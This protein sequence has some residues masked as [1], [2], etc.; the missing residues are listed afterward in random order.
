MKLTLGILVMVLVV[1]IAVCTAVSIILN[2]QN[3]EIS[4]D[5][6][7]KSLNIVRDDLILRKEKLMSDTHQLSR[8]NSMGSRVKYLNEF[9]DNKD[10][11]MLKDTYYEIISDMLQIGINSNLWKIAVYDSDGD[12]RT[13][14]ANNGQGKL[15][16]GYTYFAPKFTVY[17][18]TLEP[19][20]Q[21]TTDACQKTGALPQVGIPLK[22]GRAI[23]G[24]E[25]F[26]F[27]QLQNTLSLTA[28]APATATAF[29]KKTKRPEEIQTGLIVCMDKLGNAFV[30]R[31]SRLTG[32]RINVFGRKGLSVGDLKAYKTLKMA[33][34]GDRSGA[35]MLKDQK[36]LLNDV[37]VDDTAYYQGV[38][39]L[40]N[41]EGRV[42]A[43]AALQSKGV[44]Y[45]RTIQMIELLGLV[46]LA[47]I[48]LIIPFA[49]W[50]SNSLTKPVHRAAS[51]LSEMIEE[52][53]TASTQVSSSTHV[54][55]EGTSEQAA[56]LEE[57]ASS[58]EEMSSM[59]GRSA[60]NASEA[61][62]LMRETN[63]I[64][65]KA[66]ESMD[67]LSGSMGE[68]SK[69]SEE[70]SRI[71]K[72]I[73]E[74]AFQTNL[75]ALNAAVE[76]ARAGE[77]GAGFAVV[78][79]EVRNL[80]MRAAEAAKDTAQL[81]EGTVK[82][83][84]GGTE[85]VTETGTAFA[86]VNTNTTKAGE[87]IN[88]ISLA[89]NEQAQG[90]EQVNKAVSEMDRVVQQNAASSEESAAAAQELDRQAVR[91]KGIIEDLNAITGALAKDMAHKD[92]HRPIESNARVNRLP[93]GKIDTES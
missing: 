68:I 8:V 19:G 86:D 62:S 29:N 20:E 5:Q 42:G 55:A 90:I 87:L 88:E 46:F 41:G 74:I 7:V 56:S 70:T 58:L 22:F 57:S 40:Y 17:L 2:R 83:I 28:Y 65:E 79:D 4:E 35:Q 10:H 53:S 13:F 64:V 6:V 21:L 16:V 30:K 59:I 60:T 15:Q 81:I 49:Y 50:F 9:K 84:K 3:R 33:Q 34:L 67:R 44:S 61:D 52:V 25:G 71:I 38:L 89:S 76:A 69:A 39:P 23:P 73:D 47:C 93:A 11:M 36:V 82:K 72:T 43:I 78:A 51:A 45:A 27:G 54:L 92:A 85:M 66:N 26:R 77:A 91:L 12:L 32:M 1:M 31:M 14:L 18:A 24:T 37:S 48:L 80:A 75:L 63:Q